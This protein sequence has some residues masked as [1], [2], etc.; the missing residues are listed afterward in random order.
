MRAQ[1][2]E[3]MSGLRRFAMEFLWFG[4]KE[5]R[6]CLFAGLFFACLFLVP[7]G[8]VFGV[9]L[10]DVLLVLAL[11]IQAWMLAAGLESRDVM[12]AICQF[13]VVGFV[14]EEFKTS[15]ARGYWAYPA[16]GWNIQFRVH[17]LS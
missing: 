16:F 17:L 11:A 3:G 1:A 8:G 9:P 6:A 7:R 14:T 15:P 13:H 10:Y 5:A 2:P 4:M 12:K